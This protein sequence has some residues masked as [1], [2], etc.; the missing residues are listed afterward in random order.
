[1]QLTFLGTSAGKPTRE[2]N[3][4]ALA[5]EFEQDNKWYLFDCGEATQH[6]IL[7]SRLSIGKL[8]TI[9][10]THMHGDHY[11]GLPGLLSSKK[12]DTAFRPLTLYGPTGI[13]KFLECVI[14]VSF[15][16]LGYTLKIIEYKAEETF[17][18]DKFS[19][20]VLSLEHSIESFAFYIKENDITNRLN[21]AKLRSFGLEP[22]PLY[23]ELQRGNC[24]TFQGKKLEP[25][26]FMLPPER[27]RRLIIAGDNS[28]PEILGRYLKEIDLLVHEC[29]YT[30]Q[31]YDHLQAK[32]LHTTAKD[33]GK[34]VQ[35]RH[36]KN[37]IA[38]HINPR[39][40]NHS[41]KGTDVLYHEIKAY[42][43]GRVFIAN[44][45]DVYRLSKDGMV[46]KL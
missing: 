36:V 6:Q 14:D 45:L 42:Y 43:K 35:K 17:G 16:N 3:V 46:E 2:R 11:Y 30:Q 27:G 18:F 41:I 22:S 31:D 23:G 7:R 29:T 32:V 33:L 8:D 19:L 38:S 10:I 28:K 24:I 15:E 20:K 44:D 13:K 39:Y 12:L 9:F 21:E 37:V 25:G 40:N 26:E 1:M 5:L 4:S 34:A